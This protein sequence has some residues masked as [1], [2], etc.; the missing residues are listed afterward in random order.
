MTLTGAG[1]LC[2]RNSRF[3][4]SSK[5]PSGGSVNSRRG[6]TSSSPS[7][8]VSHKKLKGSKSESDKTDIDASLDDVDD[9]SA[10]DVSSEQQLPSLSTDHRLKDKCPCN[11]S[12]KSSWKLDCAKCGQWWHTDC[13]GLKGISQ[14]AISLLTQYHCPFCY[15]SPI[16][17]L[18]TTVDVCHVCRNTLTLQQTN[19][20]VEAKLAHEKIGNMAKCCNILNNID[21]DMLSKNIE[22]IAQFDS[23]LKH[24][25]LKKI[26]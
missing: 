1:N 18:S 22:T 2:N 19:L 8:V 24:L 23:H 9:T 7:N 16:P 20:D 10:I 25:L 21:F 4:N 17:T 5:S 11:Q 3:K 13:V 15:I 6:S 26:H 14:K 12:I